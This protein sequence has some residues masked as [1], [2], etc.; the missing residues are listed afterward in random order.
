[1]LQ[2]TSVTSRPFGRHAVTVMLSGACSGPVVCQRLVDAVSRSVEVDRTG[3]VIDLR[4]AT[5]LGGDVLEI[6]R[7]INRTGDRHGWRVVVVKP[8]GGPLRTL[9]FSDALKMDMRLVGTRRA[10]LLW[11]MRARPNS[12][13]LAA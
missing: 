4:G 3:I 13:G 11:A 6:I 5:G 10:A 2:P 7:D 1:M 9:F 12:T 8:G